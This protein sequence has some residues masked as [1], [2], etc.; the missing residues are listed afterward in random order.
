MAKTRRR[1][2]EAEATASLEALLDRLVGKIKG[3]EQYGTTYED[4]EGNYWIDGADILDRQLENSPLLASY[5]I[6]GE[7]V[8]L[9]FDLRAVHEFMEGSGFRAMDY[10]EQDAR[11][12]VQEDPVGLLAKA[13]REYGDRVSPYDFVQEVE[14]W[15]CEHEWIDIRNNAVQS[16]SMCRKCQMLRAENVEEATR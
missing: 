7:T 12:D 14:P 15:R 10:L 8:H 4:D 5:K 11:D 13:Y 2:V 16:G 9:T 6:S 3:Y 1:A